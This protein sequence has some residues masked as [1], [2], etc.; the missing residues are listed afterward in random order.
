MELPLGPG[1]EAPAHPASPSTTARKVEILED[2]GS[3][4]IS[5]LD[6]EH[7]GEHVESLKDTTP[8]SPT[9]ATEELSPDATVVSLLASELATSREVS[10]LHDGHRWI[11]YYDRLRELRLD[12]N[13]IE[14]ALVC[15][16]REDGLWLIGLRCGLLEDEDR[17]IRVES[18]LLDTVARKNGSVPIRELQIK[19]GPLA[20]PEREAQVPGVGVEVECSVVSGEE[21]GPDVRDLC[22]SPLPKAPPKARVEGEGDIRGGSSVDAIDTKLAGE[23]LSE[24]C[25][26]ALRGEP[27]F[28]RLA[29]AAIDHQSKVA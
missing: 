13:S 1:G 21:R 19:P 6:D 29:N 11:W 17:A 2:E 27:F 15:V 7:L 25:Q 9:F 4:S 28:E 20:V 10:V 16:E 26:R 5:R 12:E 3:L 18:Q 23:T 24:L 22:A 8:L 14:R